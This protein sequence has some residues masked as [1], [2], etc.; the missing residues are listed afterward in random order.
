MHIKIKFTTY[1]IKENGGLIDMEFQEVLNSR[2]SIRKYDAL[3]LDTLIMGIR[4]GEAD[5]PAR[6]SVVDIARFY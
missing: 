3:G 5:M 2:R 4:A 1:D 6:K